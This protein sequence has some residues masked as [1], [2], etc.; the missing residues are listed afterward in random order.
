MITDLQ[1]DQHTGLYVN[2]GPGVM[3]GTVVQ[4][5]K[6]RAREMWG[7]MQN[8]GHRYIKSNPIRSENN[9]P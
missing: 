4:Y 2:R 7:W 6:K 1:A 5:Y 9:V 3:A 8:L